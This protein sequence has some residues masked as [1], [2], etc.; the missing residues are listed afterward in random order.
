MKRIM[1]IIAIVIASLIISGSLAAAPDGRVRPIQSEAVSAEFMSVLQEGI[2]SKRI[3]T[4]EGDYYYLGQ[5]SAEY[6]KYDKK[7]KMFRLFDKEVADIVILADISWEAGGNYPSLTD[8]GCGFVFRNNDDARKEEADSYLHSQIVLEG[9]DFFW[10]LNKDQFVSYGRKYFADPTFGRKTYQVAIFANGRDTSVFINGKEVRRNLDVAV[11]TPGLIHYTVQ[12]GTDKDHGMRCKFERINLFVPGERV[13]AYGA[14]TD[15]EIF[16]GTAVVIKDP[17]SVPVVPDPPKELPEPMES[18]K[19]VPELEIEPADEPLPAGEPSESGSEPEGES[20]DEASAPLMP[21]LPP[22]PPT[23]AATITPTEDPN[24]GS[25]PIMPTPTEQIIPIGPTATV[26]PIEYPTYDENWQPH[27]SKCS[28][29]MKRGLDWGVAIEDFS[30]CFGLEAFPPDLQKEVDEYCS[31]MSEFRESCERG[32]IPH[33]FHKYCIN[34]EKDLQK[35]GNPHRDRE[36]FECSRDFNLPK[37]ICKMYDQGYATCT[38]D[39]SYREST[40]RYYILRPPR[41]PTQ[42]DETILNLCEAC[43]RF[44]D[45]KEC[46]N[47]NISDKPLDCTDVGAR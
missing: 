14:D 28:S 32:R 33:Y 29:Q 11:T 6:G 7:F 31:K 18:P 8:S 24:L 34:L 36:I 43:T 23:P 26:P 10:G 20:S 21:P 38:W 25:G 46:H 22:W 41:K 45:I 12:S 37:V 40:C 3:D 27:A 1:L 30:L 47:P 17:E 15:T 4:L 13:T 44:L 19:D 9:K 35:R 16:E 5:F 42:F 2:Q 39:D